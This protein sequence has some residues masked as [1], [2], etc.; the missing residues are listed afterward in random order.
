[1][2]ISEIAGCS[3]FHW[4]EVKSIIVDSVSAAGF[5]CQL[6]SDA[7]DSGVIHQ[8]IIQN[9]YENEIVVC[10]VSA[11]NPNVMFELGMRLAFDKPTIIVKDDQTPYSFDTSVIEHLTY[12][13]DLRYSKILEFSQLL[14]RKV[15]STYQKSKSDSDSNSFLKN[16]GNFTV[17]NFNPKEVPASQML[18]EEI[19]RMRREIRML[20]ESN[21]SRRWY[22]SDAAEDDAYG[23]A[24]LDFIKTGKISEEELKFGELSEENIDKLILNV[25][26]KIGKWFSGEKE[27]YFHAR[28]GL[29]RAFQKMTVNQANNRIIQ[30]F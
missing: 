7:D 12:P 26:P 20:S 9:L 15:I 16:F 19:S 28:T 4:V 14:T 11:K 30:K 25:K 17:A 18:L 2:P 8:R 23:T 10:D 22:L 5:E 21:Q 29:A 13:R 24:I 6:V 1:M 27:F 3:E